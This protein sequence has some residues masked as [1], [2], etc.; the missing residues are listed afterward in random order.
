[1]NSFPWHPPFSLLLCLSSWTLNH[2]LYLTCCCKCI[3]VAVV[4]GSGGAE[5]PLIPS[6]G[7]RGAELTG[8]VVGGF[9]SCLCCWATRM[10]FCSRCRPRSILF[11]PGTEVFLWTATPTAVFVFFLLKRNRTKKYLAVTIRGT[12]NLL[13]PQNVFE[14]INS[15]LLV[16][17]LRPVFLLS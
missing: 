15:W 9:W 4:R 8:S 16:T 13:N 14:N 7:W 1:M 3:E 2:R 6:M 11:L 12:F 17:C 10:A 5:L